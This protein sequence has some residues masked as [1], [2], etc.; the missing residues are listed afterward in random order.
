MKNLLIVLLLIA[1]SCSFDKDKGSGPKSMLHGNWAFLDVRGNYNE[2]FFTDSTYIT[3]NMVYG[4]SPVFKYSIKND[5]FY[6]NIGKNRPGLHWIG[7]VK[8]ISPD[9]IIIETEFSRDTLGRLTGEKVT[10]ENT[11]PKSDSVLF[12]REIYRRYEQFLLAKGIIR[13]EEIEEFKKTSKIPEDLHK[14]Q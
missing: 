5:S 9:T 12:R 8:I 10:I 3:Y 7:I 11:D 4:L 2:A 14:Q 6:C 1:A 13:P